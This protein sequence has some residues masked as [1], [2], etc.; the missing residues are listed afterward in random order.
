MKDV[1]RRFTMVS[2]VVEGRLG[3]LADLLLEASRRDD[4]N[5]SARGQEA[6]TAGILLELSGKRREAVKV[7]KE[8]IRKFPPDRCCFWA[9]LAEALAAKESDG[10]E[11]MPLFWRAR[12]EMSYLAGLLYEHRGDTRRARRLFDLSLK[13]D[14]TLRWPAFMARQSLSRPAG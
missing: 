6:V 9:G 8:A 4:G 7:W 12:S 11:S 2:H 3:E 5:Q 14:P 13:E 10:I 1:L